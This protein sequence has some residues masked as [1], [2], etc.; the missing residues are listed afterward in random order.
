[1]PDVIIPPKNIATKFPVSNASSENITK[2]QVIDTDPHFN[3]VIQ[4]MRVSDYC[5]CYC[6]CCW[7]CCSSRTPL[8]YESIA[9]SDKKSRSRTPNVNCNWA[10]WWIS[11]CIP[12]V[13]LYVSLC[14]SAKIIVRFWG[15]TEN[16]AESS[17]DQTEMKQK[18]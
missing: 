15:W 12:T 4:Y 13:E 11:H 6:Y 2:L 9:L 17:R 16:A 14:N 18:V 7:T 5:L 3:R 8:Y 1:M 10:H